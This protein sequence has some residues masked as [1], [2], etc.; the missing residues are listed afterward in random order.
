[1]FTTYVYIPELELSDDVITEK[2]NAIEAVAQQALQRSL[3]EK[4]SNAGWL[5]ERRF[6]QKYVCL[7]TSCN[8]CSCLTSDCKRRFKYDKDGLPRRW[9]YRD[10]VKKEFFAARN[11][12]RH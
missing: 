1:M 3:R 6:A 7:S 12:V 5:M 10:N 2:V 11:E 4:A 8:S 9:S